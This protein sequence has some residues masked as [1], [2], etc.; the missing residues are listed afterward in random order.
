MS[1]TVGLS[2][3]PSSTT[4][5]AV[6]FLNQANLRERKSS[7]QGNQISTEYVYASGDPTYETSVLV[8]SALDEKNNVLRSSISLRTVQTVTVDSVV[9]EVDQVIASLSWT[10]PGRTEDTTKVL[11]M[12]GT[13]YSLA[14]NGVTSKVPNTGTIDAINR[15]I[16]EG[17]FS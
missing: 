17:L 10:T 6:A 8:T 13:L 16:T 5:V 14:F 11:A 4:D 2:N 12:L 9:T 7:Q 3:M 15:G 1:T